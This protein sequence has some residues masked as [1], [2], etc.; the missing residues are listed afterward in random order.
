MALRK[1]EPG[2]PD[3]YGIC[4][5]TGIK[6][7]TGARLPGCPD[8][9]LR[10]SDT[11][12]GQPGEISAKRLDDRFMLNFDSRMSGSQ[13]VRVVHFTSA[14]H[15]LTSITNFSFRET[16]WRRSSAAVSPTI[17]RSRSGVK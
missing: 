7:V 6:T 9:D 5:D 11:I 4:Q 3:R 13:S 10:A 15:I 16:Y 17:S 8:S 14:F 2:L 12:A 1:G